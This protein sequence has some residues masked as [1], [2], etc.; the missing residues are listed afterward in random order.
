MTFV[1]LSG[2]VHLRVLVE[3]LMDAGGG[4]EVLGE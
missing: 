1:R 2:L 3:G 4:A